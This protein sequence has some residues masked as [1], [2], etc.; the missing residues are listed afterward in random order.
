MPYTTYNC[1]ALTGGGSRALDAISVGSLADGDRAKCM[2]SGKLTHFKFN[3][4]GTDAE[5]V[6]VH[7]YTVRPDDY[8][9]GPGVW[10][11]QENDIVR[12]V[13]VSVLDYGT[14]V[15][16]GDGKW[17]GHIPPGLNGWNL[18]YVHAKVITPGT[19]GT[20]DIQIHNIT[21][22]VDILSTKLTIDSGETGSDTAETPAVI[23][24]DNDDVATNDVLRIDVD[25]VHTTK[26]KGLIVTLGFQ[27]P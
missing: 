25:A 7:P 13:Q 1:N 12:Y 21:Q 3:A 6:S 10:E 23:D 14:F 2:V 5:N 19:T 20:L 18:G 15:I 8:G 22:A 9:A 17:Y 11:E 4:S 26:P 27:L 24:T 16:V